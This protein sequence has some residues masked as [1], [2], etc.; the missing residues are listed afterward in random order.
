MRILTG[1]IV[2][3]LVSSASASEIK[4]GRMALVLCHSPAVL[5]DR[6][7]F[8]EQAG[9]TEYELKYFTKG[10]QSALALGAGET[11]VAFF[12]AI[13]PA[14]ANGLDARIIAINSK[15]GVQLV[16]MDPS[17]ERLADLKG[18]RIGHIGPTS[19]PTTIFRAA[20]KEAGFPQ[21]ELQ[22]QYINRQN[23]AVALTEQAIVDCAVTIE[24][25]TSEAIKRGATMVLDEKQLYKNNDYPFTFVVVR[26]DY[27]SENR[28]SVEKLLKAHR[29]SQRFLV[30]KEASA[31]EE[32]Q[33][34]FASNGL[35]V[36]LK[37]LDKGM[38]T[39]IFDP[40]ISR[41]VMEELVD[42]MVESDVL[43]ERVSFE[44]LVDC[45]FGLCV[46]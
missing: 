27:A 30:E 44:D 12:G 13:V 42:V 18:K 34:Y 25:L 22:L 1:L 8:L 6:E 31:L 5:L 33:A 28:A 38:S 9:I 35:D 36:G 32:I 21:E 37:E 17:I 23:I 7:G 14:I 39:N 46:D 26:R 20:L 11:D 4:I 15:G 24:P 16:C 10:S 43:D 29:L 3:A 41:S 2:A 19:A 40:T 45:S